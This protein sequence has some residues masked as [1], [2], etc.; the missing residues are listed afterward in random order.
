V[1][2]RGPR[3]VGRPRALR[4]RARDEGQLGRGRTQRPRSASKMRGGGGVGGGRRRCV[5]WGGRAAQ[6]GGNGSRLGKMK[7]KEFWAFSFTFLFFSLSI[8]LLPF[9]FKIA[10][11]FEFKIYHAL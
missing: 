5:G 1:K 9:L 7:G 8:S 2:A 10:L 4:E 3:G 11:S 6:E